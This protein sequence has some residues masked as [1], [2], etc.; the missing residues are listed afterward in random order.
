MAQIRLPDGGDKRRQAHPIETPCQPNASAHCEYGSHRGAERR[1]THEVRS[2]GPSGVAASPSSHPDRIQDALCAAGI[3]GSILCA[4]GLF[5]GNRGFVGAQP[6]DPAWVLDDPRFH[7]D[8]V[9]VLGSYAIVST[10]LGCVLFLNIRLGWPYL[11]SRYTWLVVLGIF[12]AS[13]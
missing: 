5:L 6:F 4:R 11:R 8:F 13:V 3:V 1:Q 12:L 9:V 2:G 7:S 10:L